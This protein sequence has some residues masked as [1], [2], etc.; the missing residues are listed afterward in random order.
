MTVIP[1]VTTKKRI[2]QV[3]EWRSNKKNGMLEKE[4]S[5]SED[6]IRGPEE[7]KQCKTYIK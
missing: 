6:D 1:I 7:Q 4:S 2:I 5:T 3:R